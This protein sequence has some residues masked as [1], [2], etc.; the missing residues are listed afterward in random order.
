MKTSAKIT[1]KR[2]AVTAGIILALGLCS[3]LDAGCA[4]NK[5]PKLSGFLKDYSGLKPLPDD[6][7]MLYW[8][9][10]GVN[11]K[12]YTKLTIDPVAVHLA[13]GARKYEIPPQD[14]QKLA[15]MFRTEAVAAVRD[16]Y[17]IVNQPGPDVLRIRAAITDANPSDALMNVVSA[18]A[19]FMPI[20]MGGAS[21]ETEFMDS[22]TGERLA[23]VVDKKTGSMGNPVDMGAYSKWGHA[24][25]AFEQWAKELRDNLDDA[26]GKKKK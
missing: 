26:H 15:E 18:A 1:S 8:E 2:L 25:K 20:D 23:A 24:K 5:P 17:P 22:M 11:W 4:S 12:K 6:P 21:M 10:R 7:S 3:L 14:L 16:A 13:P 19:I 9:R